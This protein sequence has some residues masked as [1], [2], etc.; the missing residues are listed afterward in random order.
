MITLS[1]YKIGYGHKGRIAG[2]EPD[3]MRSER[4]IHQP[5]PQEVIDRCLN[6]TRPTCNGACKLT[7][8]GASSEKYKEKTAK[9]KT[10]VHEERRRIAQEFERQELA[11]AQRVSKLCLDGWCES[12]IARELGLS[13][14]EVKKLIRLARKKG[15]LY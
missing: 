2:T 7:P 11:Q 10:K 14:D 4:L 12:G 1:P 15:L 13:V 3:A 9:R 8:E 6:C 5:E